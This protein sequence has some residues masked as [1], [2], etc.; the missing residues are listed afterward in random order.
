MILNTTELGYYPRL[1]S[2]FTA[3]IIGAGGIGSNLLPMI[4]RMGFGR[5]VIWDNDWVEPVNLQMQNFSAKDIGRKKSQLLR[6][7]ALSI[8]P[9]AKVKAHGRRFTHGD[10]LDGVV[11]AAVDSMKSRALVFDEAVKQRDKVTLL[12]DGRFARGEMSEFITL[13]VID[14][15]HEKQVECYRESLYSDEDA[16]H[17]PRS[18]GITAHVPYVLSG[19]IGSIL[20]RWVKDGS[21]PWK[22]THDAT[23]LH[24]ETYTVS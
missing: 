18:E 7:L 10:A 21:H 24:T 16:Y 5:F 12:V 19:L 2:G 23:T 15:N 14:L 9:E 22:V 6:D 8:N 13:Y 17:A 1:L 4:A 11:F 20:T 3:Q